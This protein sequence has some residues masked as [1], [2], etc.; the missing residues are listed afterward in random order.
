MTQSRQIRELPRDLRSYE[1]IKQKRACAYVRVSTGSEKQLQS[2]QNQTEYYE[3]YFMEQSGYIFSGIYSDAGISGSQGNRPGFVA[4]MDA[5]RSGQVDVILTKSISRF[6]RNTVLL[7]ESIREL[8]TLAVEV[9]FEEQKIHTLHAE[10]E[11]MLTVLASFAEEERRSVCKN[12]QW[13][14]RAG[15]KQGKAMV[16]ANRLLGYAKD[17]HGNLVID[18]AQAR[19]VRMI[20]KRYLAGHSAYRIAK[21]FNLEKKPSDTGRRWV[22]SRISS[23]LSNEKYMGDC[24]MQ[25][26]FVTDNG[27]EIRNT[28]QLDQ[29]Y[30]RNHHPAIIRR[31]D[32]EAVQ[33]IREGRKPRYSPLTSMLRC[34]YC[35]ASLIRVVRE[36]RWISWICAT[37]LGKGKAACRGTRIPD[38]VLQVIHAERPITEPMYV[39]EMPH[40]KTT[41]ARTKEDYQLSAAARDHRE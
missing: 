21:D 32:W 23:I 24:R 34:P 5:A 12:I 14:I 3:R 29:Y 20:Y 33:Q 28:G 41:K 27:K 30:V 35:H 16:D 25:K 10:G 15:F 1:P 9:I 18:P 31:K 17:T 40:G 2:L 4:M 38:S 8:K 6:A 36:K 37:Y 13:S 39:Q 19:L 11:L 26:Q 22:S 7:L